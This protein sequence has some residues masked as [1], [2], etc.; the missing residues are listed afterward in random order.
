MDD[1]TFRH[2]VVLAYRQVQSCRDHVRLQ[3]LAQL[4]CS[5][6]RARM[7]IRNRLYLCKINFKI[8]HKLLEGFSYKRRLFRPHH[9]HAH[10]QNG[11]QNTMASQIP[12]S[13]YIRSYLGK[14]PRPYSSDHMGDCSSRHIVAYMRPRTE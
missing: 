10:R 3:W 11:R 7:C 12:Q 6:H 5:P 13:N 14:C 9:N 4:S 2:I 1:C 8:F